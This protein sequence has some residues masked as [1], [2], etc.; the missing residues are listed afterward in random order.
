MFHIEFTLRVRFEL[1]ES[2]LSLPHSA[3]NRQP[4]GASCESGGTGLNRGNDTEY[5]VGEH[6]CCCR[7][8]GFTRSAKLS[9]VTLVTKDPSPCAPE[10]SVPKYESFGCE[11]SPE[12]KGA[13]ITP[14]TGFFL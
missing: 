13:Y 4:F 6:V 10:Y 1:S 12:A 7:R 2:R 9:G 5:F 11:E 3:I 8:R 14:T